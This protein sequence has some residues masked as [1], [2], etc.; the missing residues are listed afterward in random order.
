MKGHVGR[1]GLG[2]FIIL[3]AVI[4]V[5]V[6]A[7]NAVNSKQDRGEVAIMTK[8]LKTICAGRFLIDLPKDAQV[9]LSQSSI[10]GFDITTYPDDTDQQF[11]ERVK[12]REAEINGEKN[13]FGQKNLESSQ[14][15]RGAGRSGK[16]FVYG[17]TSTHVYHGDEKITLNGVSVSAYLRTGGVSFSFAASN[18]DPKLVGSLPKLIA[19]LK[20]V[21]ESRVPVEPGFC[22]DRAVVTD[23]LSADQGERIVMFAS[24]PNH[25]DVGIV[26]SS[27]AGT[28][29]GPGLLERN[30]ENR[31]KRF[32][33]L[34]G[35]FA[36][37]REGARTINGLRGEELAVRVREIN[38]ATTYGFDWEMGGKEDDV[39]NPFL[40]L[41][42]QA[43]VNPRPGGPPV[44]ST[45]SEAALKDLWDT[46][47]SSIR[48]RPSSQPTVADAEPQGA[49]L[50]TYASAGDLCPH[51]GWWLCNEG[52]GAVGVLGGQLQYLKRGQRMPQALLLPPQTL[53]QKVRGVQPSY[54]RSIPTAW[55]LVDKRSRA[56]TAP[57]VA[58]EPATVTARSQ[59]MRSQPGVSATGEKV[60]VG[61]YVK[62]GEP[63]PASGWWRCEEPQALDGT[64]WF[65]QGSLLPS[66]TF[67]VPP[68]G[69]GKPTGGPEVIQR[70]SVWQLARIA[71][72][73]VAKFSE[74]EIGT[75]NPAAAHSGGERPEA[76]SPNSTV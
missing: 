8:Q 19:K 13:Q 68:R 58:L 25:P 20:P 6:S 5:A 27:M 31:A 28:K 55:E 24:L 63:C 7:T 17:R 45:L 43:G 39:H 2:V 51:S 73:E 38:F 37:L 23:P 10:D 21:P 35:L 54:E 40:T 9:A 34:N 59:A 26:F 42:L 48:L 29:P 75:V 76:E 52:G 66:A 61:S 15:I 64:R 44:Q 60:K 3:A 16:I 1:A 30:A 22:I 70:R 65:V 50:G 14:E 62:T 4:T 12:K 18:F 36:T 71:H 74:D 47:S 72:I 67:R 32:A 33:F 49:A 69:F 11:A 41:E 53:W 46:V 56:R 57:P